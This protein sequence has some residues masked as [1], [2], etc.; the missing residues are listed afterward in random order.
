MN[1]QLNKH[2]LRNVLV[3]LFIGICLGWLFFS[4]SGSNT[5]NHENETIHLETIWT[6]SMHPQIRLPQPGKC[7]ICAMDLIPV[8]NNSS[9]EGSLNQAGVML[10]ESA[11]KLA[12]IRTSRVK[13]KAPENSIYLFGRVKED[14]RNIAKLSARFGGRIEGL[15]VN[16]TGQQVRKD[17]ILGT[18]YSPELLT[19]QKELI[20]A[21]K[22]KDTN[23]SFYI[24]V[25]RKLELWG[26]SEN[27]IEQIEKNQDPIVN[28]NI[29][30]PISGTVTKRHIS[31]GEYVKEGS[32]LFEVVDLSRIW[33]I[34]EAYETDLSWIHLNDRITFTLAALPG[35]SYEGK[36]TYIDPFLD[37]MTRIAKVRVELSN[38]SYQLKPEMYA[39]G[40]LKSTSG[41]DQST[42][43][44]PRSSV[45]W[46]G[47][48]AIVY[49]RDQ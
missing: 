39:N 33:V 7:P 44:I 13:A 23:P 40:V 4:G 32:E 31:T 47:K 34:F 42:L 46:T 10:S 48:R 17:Q 49:V 11:L 24:S 1:F 16:F 38:P 30:S 12:D 26:I 6:C 8:S 15:R 22:L 14:E 18:I 43:L 3:T 25:R 2:E 36:I 28:F 41:F 9:E 21:K 45:L 29:M 27:Q 5:N 20:E 19:T 37:P 35:E